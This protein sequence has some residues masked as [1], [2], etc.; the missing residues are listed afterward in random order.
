V[1]LLSDINLTVSQTEQEVIAEY[2]Y[3]IQNVALSPDEKTAYMIQLSRI[4]VFDTADPTKMA[5]ID[6]II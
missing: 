2:D 5:E 1:R 6:Q 4:R 3:P